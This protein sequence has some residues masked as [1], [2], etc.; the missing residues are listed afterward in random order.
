MQLPPSHQ[1]PLAVPPLARIRSPR[2]ASTGRGNPAENATIGSNEKTTKA[3]WPVYAQMLLFGPTTYTSVI[4]QW[5]SYL[6]EL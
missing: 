2:A 1:R 5:L 6:A 4:S 3:I